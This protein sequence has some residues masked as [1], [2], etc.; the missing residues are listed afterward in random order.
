MG[1]ILG[2]DWDNG[3]ENGNYYR[4][5]ELYGDNVKENG[6]CCLGFRAGDFKHFASISVS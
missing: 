6:S 4:I 2:L 1:D 5:L 3:K